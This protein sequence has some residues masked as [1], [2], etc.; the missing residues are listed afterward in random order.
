MTIPEILE[1]CRTIAVVG[2]SS[3]PSRPSFG[4]SEYMQAKGYKII[5]VNPNELEVLGETAYDRLEDFAGPVDIVNVFRRSKY[6]SDVIDSAIHIQAKV[7]WLQEGVVDEM[8]ARRARDA[9]LAVVMNRCIL[10]EHKKQ[11]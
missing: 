7:V 10:K 1:T 11:I 5:P 9:G 8:A 3:N 4:V 6:V 2:L